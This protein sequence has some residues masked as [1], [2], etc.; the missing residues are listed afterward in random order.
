MATPPLMK[1]AF[2]I[3]ALSYLR[4]YHIFETHS[5]RN[6]PRGVGNSDVPEDIAQLYLTSPCSETTIVCFAR[7]MA[8]VRVGGGGGAGLAGAAVFTGSLGAGSVL[9]ADDSAGGGATIY[10]DHGARI[11][12][13]PDSVPDYYF[14]V[15]TAKRT[16][17]NT[18][19]HH[20]RSQAAG[21]GAEGGT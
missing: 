12:S 5:G 7:S 11:T 16:S 19:R 10:M 18:A 8:A 21:L 14:A 1:T 20:A 9:G 3:G 15:K 2:G 4:E 17:S 6:V 13:C